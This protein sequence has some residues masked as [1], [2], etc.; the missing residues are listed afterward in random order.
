MTDWN[1]YTDPFTL[2]MIC[3]SLMDDDIDGVITPE[4][5]DF[6]VEEDCLYENS[7][8][9]TIWLKREVPND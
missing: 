4:I 2:E 7:V 8:R 9:V 5:T 3:E 6:D 1:P